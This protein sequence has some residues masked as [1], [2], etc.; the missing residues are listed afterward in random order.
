MILLETDHTSLL[1]MPESDR[2]NRL[3]A[4]MALNHPE[5]FSLPVIVTEEIMRGWLS[6][7]ARER[8]PRRQV[9]AYRELADMFSFF[10][11]FTIVLFDENAVEKLDQLQKQK[12]RIGTMDLKIASIAMANNALLLTANRRDFEQVPGLKFENWMDPP[13]VKD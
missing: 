8:Q 1:R 11:L 13:T 7:I 5:S 3:V 2:R 4:R 6:S 10:A 9:F 12:V